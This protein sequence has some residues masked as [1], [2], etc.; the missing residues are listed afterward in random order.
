MRE[1]ACFHGSWDQGDRKASC[2]FC[3]R[4]IIAL[5]LGGGSK[6]PNRKAPLRAQGTKRKQGRREIGG[7]SRRGRF[8]GSL[9]NLKINPTVMEAHF[10]PWKF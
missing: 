7:L 6:V 5:H 3:G 9:D 2:G 8:Y 10:L 1:Y 4:L